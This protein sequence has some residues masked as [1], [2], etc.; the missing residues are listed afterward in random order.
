MIEIKHTLSQTSA[1]PRET[2]PSRVRGLVLGLF[3]VA[4]CFSP[5][6][7]IIRLLDTATPSS[8]DTTDSAIAILCWKALLIGILNLLAATIL[9]GGVCKTVSG[10]AS[11]LGHIALAAG[12]QALALIGFTLSF[13]LT[14]AATA[15]LLISLNPLWAAI[16]SWLVFGE[17]LHLRTVIALTAASLSLLFVFLPDLIVPHHSS[18]G[19]ESAMATP[20][21]ASAS[22]PALSAF[23]NLI[24]IATGTAVAVY[25]VVVRHAAIHCPRV[26]MS[27]ASGLGSLVAGALALALAALRGLSVVVASSDASASSAAAAVVPREVPFSQ[28][29]F[30]GFFR[31]VALDATL[32]AGAFVLQNLALREISGTE[33]ALVLLLQ[34]GL[35]PL[36]VY[37][38][39]GEVPSL[40]TM[41]GGTLLLVVLAAHELAGLLARIAAASSKTDLPGTARM[42]PLSPAQVD[43]KPCVAT[44]AAARSAEG[45]VGSPTAPSHPLSSPR[46]KP[47]PR[48]WPPPSPPPTPPAY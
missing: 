7:L 1:A 10:V 18:D 48:A 47:P 13:L 11:G 3:A 26:S 35:G 38:G 9:E 15:L 28:F 12:L 30:G 27:V 39:I 24:A 4:F 36:Y 43:P 44:T 41:I 25:L 21:S 6:A 37:L 46:R 23:P 17:A 14:D 20:A 33:V 40:W 32:L 42:P 29:V 5:D 22:P 31:L 8:Y 19:T 34:V 16:L 45:G 2:K